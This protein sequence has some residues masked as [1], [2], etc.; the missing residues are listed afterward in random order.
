MS[1][2][3]VFARQHGSGDRLLRPGASNGVFG[4]GDEPFRVGHSPAASPCYLQH[5]APAQLGNVAGAIGG[6]ADVI[7]ET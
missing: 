2:A 3:E 4:T 1:P 5:S 6:I 7:L